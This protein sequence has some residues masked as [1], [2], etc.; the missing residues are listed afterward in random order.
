MFLKIAQGTCNSSNLST[1]FLWF[2]SAIDQYDTVTASE[3]SS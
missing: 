1:R 2:F 3:L